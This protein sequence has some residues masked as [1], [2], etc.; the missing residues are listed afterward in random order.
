MPPTLDLTPLPQPLRPPLRLLILGY[1]RPY[2]GV[3]VAISA[4]RLLRERNV[5]AKLTVVGEFWDP[6]EGYQEQ[7]SRPSAPTTRWNSVPDM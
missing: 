4:T 2:K 5:D 3:G 1:V 7:V 6:V